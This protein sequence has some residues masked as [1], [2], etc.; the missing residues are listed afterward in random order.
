M[1]ISCDIVILID[2]VDTWHLIGDTYGDGAQLVFASGL[3]SS[4]DEFTMPEYCSLI[5]CIAFEVNIFSKPI[6]ILQF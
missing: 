2:F 6:F 4:K 1:R 5:G 3:D